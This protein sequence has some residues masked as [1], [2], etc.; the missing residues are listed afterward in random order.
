ELLLRTGLDCKLR[1]LLGGS[2]VDELLDCTCDG[3]AVDV[4]VILPQHAG[5]QETLKLKSLVNCCCWSTGCSEDLRC[6]T[7]SCCVDGCHV[8]SPIPSS[9][10][11]PSPIRQCCRE[12][13]L[14]LGC[15][16]CTALH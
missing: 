9:I 4:E 5:V 2:L 14:E 16:I 13:R 15:A 11:L 1:T 7:T 6:K 10:R 8:I 12:K 3:L